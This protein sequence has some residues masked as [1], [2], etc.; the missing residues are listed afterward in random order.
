MF[1]SF[2]WHL[3]IQ[4]AISLPPY[5]EVSSFAYQCLLVEPMYGSSRPQVQ[6]R[7]VPWHTATSC[8]PRVTCTAHAQ[9]TQCYRGRKRPL[10]AT[11]GERGPWSWEAQITGPT[12][13]YC[14]TAL[15]I[16]K[17]RCKWE[18]MFLAISYSPCVLQHSLVSCLTRVIQVRS[19]DNTIWL[20]WTHTWWIMNRG[21]PKWTPHWTENALPK[22]FNKYL[23]T[24]IPIDRNWTLLRNNWCMHR[25]KNTHHQPCNLLNL[26]TVNNLRRLYPPATMGI[27]PWIHKRRK[28]NF[29]YLYTI[30][31][32]LLLWLFVVF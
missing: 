32:S 31:F 11:E 17:Y 26:L 14:Q 18:S 29:M 4:I 13:P 24:D 22:L 1:L 7:S 23:L 8:T 12:T 21:Y 28:Y 10:E 2:S 9:H 20:V 27:L 16:A 30:L 19:S 3:N 15:L 6:L 5:W 25:R